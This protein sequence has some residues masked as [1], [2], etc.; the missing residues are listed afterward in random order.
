MALPTF[1]PVPGPSPGTKLTVAAQLNRTEFGDGYTQITRNGI[2]FQKRTLDLN[3][4]ILTQAQADT[5]IAFF[6]ERGGDKAF[7]YK[8]YNSAVT[9]K[10]TCD[11]WPD[12]M[13][14]D[15]FRT[16]SVTLKQAYTLEV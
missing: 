3:W 5:I 12:E 1:N 2:N 13:R 6:A 7:Y 14:D 15:S 4:E 11:E 9:Y 16:I 8:P 10:W